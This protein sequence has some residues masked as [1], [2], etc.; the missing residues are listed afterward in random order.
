MAK[1]E[2]SDETG[3]QAEKIEK[4]GYLYEA[5]GFSNQGFHIF[6]A[7]DFKVGEQKLEES[8]HGMETKFFTLQKFEKMVEEGKIKDAPS[9][10]AYGL[11]KVKRII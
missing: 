9:I 10:C 2:L 6:L 7:S 5:Y 3:L 1:G 4:V 8:E 11:L